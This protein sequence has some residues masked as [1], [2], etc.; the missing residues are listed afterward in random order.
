MLRRNSSSRGNASPI[1]KNRR[2]INA[3]QRCSYAHA[4]AAKRRHRA[5]GTRLFFV[6][7]TKFFSDPQKVLAA[8]PG[9]AGHA[10]LRIG[11]T[12]CH[13][14]YPRCAQCGDRVG[15]EDKP[16]CAAGCLAERTGGRA[17]AAHSLIALRTRSARIAPPEDIA[18]SR[19][20]TSSWDPGC[21]GRDR[22]RGS[23]RAP[24][25]NSSTSAK[26]GGLPLRGRRP[27]AR[28]ARHMCS[29]TR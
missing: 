23:R 12:I 9:M 19:C 27:C 4:A 24:C 5:F 1:K 17:R 15:Q 22:R 20:L 21:C 25:R 2:W 3:I 29:C 26:P 28:S 16:A 6:P 10:M 13:G 18:R 11:T 8:R 7:S 14:H